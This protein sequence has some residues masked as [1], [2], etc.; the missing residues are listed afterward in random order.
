M[1]GPASAARTIS[2]EESQLEKLPPE[3]IVYITDFLPPS[4]T[5]CLSLTN[6]TLYQLIRERCK[7]EL[8]TY[9]ERLNFLNCLSRDLTQYLPCHGWLDAKLYLWQSQRNLV[10]HCDHCEKNVN[11][12]I[13]YWRPDLL[14]VITTGI[15]IWAACCAVTHG[16]VVNTNCVSFG[17][18]MLALRHEMLG[19]EYGCPMS[20]L[21]CE[22]EHE[23]KMWDAILKIKA[24]PK[25]VR[26]GN[27]MIR[28]T[29]KYISRSVSLPLHTIVGPHTHMEAFNVLQLANDFVDHKKLPGLILNGRPDTLLNSSACEAQLPI[30]EATTKT[31]TP[32]TKKWYR[33]SKVMKCEFCATDARFFVRKTINSSSSSTSNVN[34]TAS[35]KY[36]HLIQVYQDFGTLYIPMT[37]P[38]RQL[39]DVTETIPKIQAKY[40]T[41]HEF[42][43]RLLQDLEAKWNEPV[44]LNVRGTAVAE[45]EMNFSQT[46]MDGTSSEEM[47]RRGFPGDVLLFSHLARDGSREAR[48]GSA[49]T[50][51]HGNGNG[52]HISISNS[53]NTHRSKRSPGFKKMVGMCGE[54]A[55]C[56]CLAERWYAKQEMSGLSHFEPYVTSKMK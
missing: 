7:P 34:N 16:N 33:Y 42:H 23:Y 10:Y 47:L 15:P 51:T 56:S 48:D 21:A 28:K 24:I 14:G 36:T 41:R 26:G 40:P 17:G 53:S 4:S 18:R 8:D 32:I 19:P 12:R 35:V 55:P 30:E 1:I 37:T 25:I 29:I 13:K 5:I 2:Q 45:M 9:Q 38:Q 11:H 20:G 3:L 27:L 54:E 46:T 31:T 50:S 6:R 22:C 49:S 52:S 39:I 44:P 43:E